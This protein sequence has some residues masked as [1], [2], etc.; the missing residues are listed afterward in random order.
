MSS[1]HSSAD[2]VQWRACHLILGHVPQIKST[3]LE[4]QQRGR[5]QRFIFSQD[6]RS[7]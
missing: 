1:E 2:V 7:S 5:G 4:N 6:P 3:F